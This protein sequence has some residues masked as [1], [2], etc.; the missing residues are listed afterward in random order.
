M[1]ALLKKQATLVAAIMADTELVKGGLT[2][3]AED[4]GDII[5]QLNEMQGK[6]GVCAIVSTPSF[7]N[8]NESGMPHGDGSVSISVLENVLLNRGKP[9][10]LSS[11]EAAE[12]IAVLLHSDLD[13]GLILVDINPLPPTNGVAGYEVTFKTR[14]TL[15]RKG[16]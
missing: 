4:K 2:A 1:S 6:L 15:E 8:D 5:T 16:A 3:I 9:E 10:F 13:L 11:L 12:T 7:R 14:T